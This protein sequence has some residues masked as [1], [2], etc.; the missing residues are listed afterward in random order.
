MWLRG[1]TKSAGLKISDVVYVLCKPVPIFV[2][3]KIVKVHPNANF[4]T[5]RLATI[6]RDSVEHNCVPNS[7]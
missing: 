6:S 5:F 2:I 3:N 4:A 7:D 1:I